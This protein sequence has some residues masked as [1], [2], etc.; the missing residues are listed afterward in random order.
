MLSPLASAVTRR[1]FFLCIAQ[2]RRHNNF[3]LDELV[4]LYTRSQV[5][6]AL[7]LDAQDAIGLGFLQAP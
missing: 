3:D 4:T 1:C 7:A 5:R 2:S 6:N